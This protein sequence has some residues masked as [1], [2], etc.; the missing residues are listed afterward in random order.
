MSGVPD[1][2]CGPDKQEVIETKPMKGGIRMHNMTRDELLAAPE[3]DYMNE[4]QLAFFKAL[5]F[6]QL[7][8]CKERVERGKMRLA[9]LE[10][11]INAADVATIEEERRTLLHLIDRDC[12]MLPAFQQALGRI[13]DGSYGWCEETSEPIGLQRL[14]LSP[15]TTLL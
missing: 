2:R 8:E 5:L 4:A 14:L 11:P 6:E 13:E 1:V 15:S 3:S 12:R 9:E 7:N 10:R